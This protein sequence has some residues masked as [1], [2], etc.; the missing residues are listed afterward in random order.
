MAE[1]T[2]AG[3]LSRSPFVLRD[4]GRTTGADRLRPARARS[5]GGRP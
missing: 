4:V 3:S 2:R 1:G 5:R